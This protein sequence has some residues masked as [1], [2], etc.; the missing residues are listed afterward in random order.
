MSDKHIYIKGDYYEQSGSLGAG[1]ISESEIKDQP[2]F[3]G[4]IN[5]AKQHTKN[6]NQQEI[7][8]EAREIRTEEKTRF[9]EITLK[10]KFEETSLGDIQKIQLEFLQKLKDVDINIVDVDEGSIK[11]V[12][13]GSEE[14]I[15]KLQKL[16]ESGE[17]SEVSGKTI[18]NLKVIDTERDEEELKHKIENRTNLVQEIRI[19]NIEG[20]SLVKV[21][22]NYSNLREIFLIKA[23]LNGADL[24]TANLSGTNLRE[25]NLSKTNLSGAD[26]SS[27]NLT[28]A[29]LSSANL[30]NTDL[31]NA[32]L[33]D[34][35][36]SE[37]DLSGAYLLRAQVL[38]ANFFSANLTGSCIEDWN[39]NIDTNLENV[40]CDYI[41][42]KR[43]YLE[44]E[45]RYTYSNRIPQDPD[46][47]FAPGEFTKR[48]QKILETIELFFGDGIDWQIF[49]QS[50]QKLQESE[51]LTIVDGKQRQIPIVQG[52]KN[53]G[54]GSFVIE[55]GVDPDVDK[56]KFEK[57]FFEQYKP[58]LEAA[59]EKYQLLLNAKEEQINDFYQQNTQLLR[60]IELQ[61]HNQIEGITNMSN[62]ESKNSER[63]IN[64]KQGNYNENIKGNY[65]EQSGNFGIGH[66]SGGT[67]SGGVVAGTYNAADK[68]DLAEAA[69]EIKKL[70]DQLAEDYPTNS[71]TEKMTVATKAIEQIE[72]K[73]N[74]KKKAISAVKGGLLKAVETHPV[75]AIVVG[76]IKGWQQEE[77]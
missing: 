30:K 35:N 4:K 66:M 40:Q 50:F 48:Y 45:Q 8:P 69:A 67:I 75:G 39:I 74:L 26:L 7:V 76:A 22:L 13:E 6:N 38:G 63:E 58:M 1:H 23:N 2:K 71:T 44:E 34:A 12:F 32:Y 51:K 43:T 18:A 54:D 27:S 25:A 3:G 57:S 37:A 49:L 59:E 70:L 9:L 11:L 20:R 47:I 64:I 55:I 46:R 68:K 21:N 29:N 31:S 19:R 36:L 65:Y 56:E 16:I 53:T 10:G 61:A 52:I 60:V 41:Y 17:I 24:R 73:P 42:L 33:N 72:A 62:P 14:D 28:G 77:S 5:E 15:K